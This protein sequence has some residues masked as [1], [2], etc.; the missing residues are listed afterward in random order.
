MSPNIEVQ[1]KKTEPRTVAFVAMK[2][3]Y[4]QMGEAFG[5]L[6]GWIAEKGFSPAG[7]PLGRF[8]NAPGQVADE[9]LLWE[10]QCPIGGEVS[11]S[12]PDERGVGV[13]RVEGAEVAATIHKGP[14][15]EVGPTYGALVGW[16]MEN[17]YE[18]AGPA[19]EVYLS[20]PGKAIPQEFLTE[21]RFPVMKR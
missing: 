12:G 20:E 17:G 13:K 4:T 14:F 21:V 7:P 1:V 6:L 18:I 15:Q 16:I 10:L 9:E 8:F 3:P 11:P 5:E 2:G 19:E